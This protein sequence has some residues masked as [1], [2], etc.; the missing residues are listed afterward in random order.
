M[1]TNLAVCFGLLTTCRGNAIWLALMQSMRV[2]GEKITWFWPMFPQKKNEK[3]EV[4]STLL[5]MAVLIK[6]PQTL[7]TLCRERKTH[8]RNA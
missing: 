7:T 1:F 4:I 6:Q 5:K 2:E 8:T 3:Q